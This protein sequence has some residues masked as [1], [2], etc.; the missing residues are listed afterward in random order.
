MSSGTGTCGF[1]SPTRDA[2]YPACTNATQSAFFFAIGAVLKITVPA[3]WKQGRCCLGRGRGRG[4]AQHCSE[5]AHNHR[6]RQRERPSNGPPAIAPKKRI[7]EYPFPPGADA[8][9]A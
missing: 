3:S 6:A 8:L 1:R 4:A 7:V 2:S 9:R 5:T